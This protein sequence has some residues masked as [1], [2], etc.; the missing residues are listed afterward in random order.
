MSS[1]YA[2][3]VVPLRSYK[4][5][6]ESAK[7]DQCRGDD[8]FFAGHGLEFKPILVAAGFNRSGDCAADG[9][10]PRPAALLP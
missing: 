1:L 6:T 9:D 2:N 4:V 8:V 7:P 5:K 10:V 3:F